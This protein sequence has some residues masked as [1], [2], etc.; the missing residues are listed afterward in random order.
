MVPLSILLTLTLTLYFLYRVF[1]IDIIRNYENKLSNFL[2][3]KKFFIGG[4]KFNLDF[5]F[6]S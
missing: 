2:S 5:F 3:T 6:N 1:L 4:K